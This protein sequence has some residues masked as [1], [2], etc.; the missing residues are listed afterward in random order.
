MNKFW[1][2]V[3]AVVLA[4]CGLS[5][6]ISPWMGWGLPEGVSTHAAAVDF[7]WYV[8]LGITGF[9]FFLTEAILVGFLFL[10]SSEPGARPKRATGVPPALSSLGAVLHDL[11]EVIQY[12]QGLFVA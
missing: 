7:L 12:E 11:F 8:I 10:Y 2:I 4:A 1:S 5:F 9:F 6:V 3:F